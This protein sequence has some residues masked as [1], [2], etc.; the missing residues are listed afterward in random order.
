[1][2]Q[3]QNSSKSGQ[4]STVERIALIKSCKIFSLLTDAACHELLN[5]VEVSTVS[6]QEVLFYQGDPSDHLYILC[7]GKLY[8]YHLK[9]D[10][11]EKVIGLIERGETVGEL[12]ALSNLPRTLSVKALSECYLLK[13][14]R[15]N[16]QSY[17]LKHSEVLLEMINGLIKRSQDNIFLLA[18]KKERKHIAII[19]ANHHISLL[20]FSRKLRTSC[21]NTSSIL[22]LEDKE[23][24]D[25]VTIINKLHENTYQK[26]V[27]Y[28]IRE[29]DS[30]LAKVCREYIDVIF[31]IADA[32]DPYLNEMVLDFIK[33][34]APLEVRCELILLHKTS[35]ANTKSWLA[36]N[37][38][39][40]HHHVKENSDVDYQRLLR[41][42]TGKPVG[43]VLG[44]GG[45][46]AWAQIGVIKALLE[47]NIPIDAIG[48]TSAGAFVAAAYAYTANYT[49]TY[50][51][52]MRMVQALY[53]VFSIRS[54]TIPII[55]LINA[56][57]GTLVLQQ[58]FGEQLIEN[59]SLPYFCVSCN[60]N[61][62]KAV[63]HQQGP[64]WKML[65]CSA[66]IPGISP[67]VVLDGQLH[68]DGGVMNNV[69]VDMMRNLLGDVGTVVA[70]NLNNMQEDK[71]TY[72]F[73]P[74]LTFKDTLLYKMRLANKN[75]KFPFFFDTFM[76]S[77]QA[78]A[79]TYE[80]LNSLNADVLIN[81]DLRKYKMLDLDIKLA[82]E[83]IEIGYKETL[84]QLNQSDKIS[85]LSIK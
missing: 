38:F 15:T 7:S 50:Q 19:P 80:K 53:P 76:N 21:Q 44:G 83:L 6:P 30:A 81:P 67:P 11:T 3:G 71:N 39:H 49:D 51:T 37:I 34:R 55:S 46:K 5:Y 40:L 20:D 78:G 31:V 23:T 10:G 61:Q 18:E 1:M 2:D 66:S 52:A 48:G 16:F 58:I 17:C 57:K 35:I 56:K 25:V 29:Y 75:F 24:D 77:M 69:P 73:P 12:G 36:N 59:L 84:Q 85:N 70:V 4:H 27:L 60:L 72:Y 63:M 45:A 13:I 64:L 47:K 32:A 8:T 54:L 74:V 82:N 26:K 28:L 79:F 65:R 14:S 41:F 62:K 68:I 22:L 9:K 42:I 43:L 33:S